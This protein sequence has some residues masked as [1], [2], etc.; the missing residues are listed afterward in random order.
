MDLAAALN[1]RDLELHGFYAEFISTTEPLRALAIRQ[2][3]HKVLPTV[4]NTL[5]LGQMAMRVALREVNAERKK[6]L[7]DIAASSLEQARALD[8]KNKAVLSAY[9]KYYRL[10]GGLL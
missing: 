8:P 10:T 6:A 5:L 9:A 7:F 3:L 1:P 2:H 4:R